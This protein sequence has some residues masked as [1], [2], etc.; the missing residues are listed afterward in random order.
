MRHHRRRAARDETRPLSDS[1]DCRLST[2]ESA[3]LRW[4]GMNELKRSRGL[5]EASP[6]VMR[7]LIYHRLIRFDAQ[8]AP[9]LTEKGRRIA[10]GK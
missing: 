3:A 8:G 4:V 7:Y 9:V 5:G 10:S 2:E 6:G 1:D